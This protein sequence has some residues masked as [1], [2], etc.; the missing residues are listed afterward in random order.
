LYC[1]DRYSARQWRSFAS[2]NGSVRDILARAQAHSW[3][4]SPQL[5]FDEVNYDVPD[6]M[7]VRILWAKALWYATQEA[8]RRR[9][10]VVIDLFVSCVHTS[11]V[12][13]CECA[14]TYQTKAL[15]SKARRA[16]RSNFESGVLSR[17]SH[18]LSF[19]LKIH[20]RQLSTVKSKVRTCRDFFTHSLA[21]WLLL[22]LSLSLPHRTEPLTGGGDARGGAHER[23]SIETW[24]EKYRLRIGDALRDGMLCE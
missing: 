11:C 18:S 17:S 6:N 21:L 23:R 14:C 15:T 7:R 9:E 8:R 4:N 5:S 22:S 1:I 19:S 24:C 12:L 16:H 10:E 20:R 3:E 13:K 2:T